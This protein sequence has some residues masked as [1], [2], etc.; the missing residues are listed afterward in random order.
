MKNKRNETELLRV[1]SCFCI[2]DND[3]RTLEA[4]YICILVVG[5]N[6]IT[7]YLIFHISQ[8]EEKSFD[9]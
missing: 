9:K 5:K 6:L 4:I 1:K 3:I 8:E 2:N 7:I